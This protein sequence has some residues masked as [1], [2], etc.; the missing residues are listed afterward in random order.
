M[1][2]DIFIPL[3][4]FTIRLRIYLII[5]KVRDFFFQFCRNNSWIGRRNN[6]KFSL[7]NHK[8]ISWNSSKILEV[9]S[10]FLQSVAENTKKFRQLIAVEENQIRPSSRTM[11]SFWKRPREKYRISSKDRIKNMNFVNP[12]QNKHEF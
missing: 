12:L 5:V 7:N 8:I 4:S 9:N 10:C 3:N 11:T 2:R 1:A 6:L